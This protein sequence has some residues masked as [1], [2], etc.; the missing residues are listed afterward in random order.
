MGFDKDYAALISEAWDIDTAYD[1]ATNH[2]EGCRDKLDKLLG[3]DNYYS[4]EAIAHRQN[5]FNLLWDPTVS[6][7]WKDRYGGDPSKYL[8]PEHDIGEPP[9]FGVR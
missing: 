6:D 8:L 4:P 7:D 1:E 5:L 3:R 9:Y 2:E